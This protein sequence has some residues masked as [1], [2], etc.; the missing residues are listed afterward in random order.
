MTDQHGDVYLDD[1][2]DDEQQCEDKHASIVATGASEPV[3]ADRGYL[4]ALF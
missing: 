4:R 1:R 3:E 2:N